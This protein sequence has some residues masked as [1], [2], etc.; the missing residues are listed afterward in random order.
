MVFVQQL[1]NRH[2]LAHHHT[3]T[4]MHSLASRQSTLRLDANK[5]EKLLL[6]P[7]K[8]NLTGPNLERDHCA[9]HAHCHHMCFRNIIKHKVC[10]YLP[11][12]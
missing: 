10:I 9:Y 7:F 8:Q 6:T 5:T 2:K 4:I 1:A 11:I 3:Q 12:R